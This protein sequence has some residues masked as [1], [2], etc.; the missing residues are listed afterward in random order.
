[1]NNARMN[2]RGLIC[3]IRIPY[4]TG[5]AILDG[6]FIRPAL[7]LAVAAY[8]LTPDESIS[9]FYGQPA[10][11]ISLKQVPDHLGYIAEVSFTEK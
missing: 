8:A 5:K 3:T 11:D 1:M 9:R 7:D 10:Y 2:D 4:S 6:T